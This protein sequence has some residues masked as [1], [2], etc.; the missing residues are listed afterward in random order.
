MF[1]KNNSETISFQELR[2]VLEGDDPDEFTDDLFKELISQIDING[3]GEI[4]FGEFEKMMTYL[5][6]NKVEKGKFKWINLSDN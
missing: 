5:V 2:S 1:D 4:N 3:D 6:K